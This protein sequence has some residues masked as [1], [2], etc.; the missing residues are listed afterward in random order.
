M[1]ASGADTPEGELRRR[2]DDMLTE[3][4]RCQKTS[5]DGYLAGVPGSRQLWQAVGTGRVEAVNRK[6]VPYAR[7]A[8]ER[9]E[10]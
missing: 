10:W 9:E 4:E 1:I 2:L 6:W 5:N 7:A 3:L 8:G